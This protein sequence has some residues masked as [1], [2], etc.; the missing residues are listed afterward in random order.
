MTLNDKIKKYA[1]V[2]LKITLSIFGFWYAFKSIDID[3]FKATLQEANYVYVLLA[4]LIS[5]L[6]QWLSSY[7]LRYI[8]TAINDEVPAIWN[9]KLYW[10]GMAYNLF[11]PGGIGGDAYKMIAYSRRSNYP[12]K[13][14]FP[15]L[16]A[17]RLIGLCAI[18]FLIGILLPLIPDTDDWWSNNWLFILPLLAI[19]IAWLIIR[20]WFGSYASVFNKSAVQ[21]LGIQVL[22]MIAILSIVYGLG[23]AINTAVIYVFF[24]FLIS[25]IATAIPIFLG[26]L[27]AREV[28][29]ATLFP[30]FGVPAPDGVW[31]AIMFSIVVIISS[32]PGLFFG[33]SKD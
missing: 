8:L 33:F 19:P 15:P 11:L 9:A 4:I 32:V 5:L 25:S 7:R 28:V 18:V 31:I 12:A 3:M 20:K 2:G 21:S 1:W 17:D 16:L 6:S 30:L 29:F 27:G 24:V 26:G 13:N 10:Q 22:Q 14:Y 23:V